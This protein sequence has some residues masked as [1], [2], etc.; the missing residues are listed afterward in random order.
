MISTVLV[1]I[2]VIASRDTQIFYAFY[3]IIADSWRLPSVDPRLLPPKEFLFSFALDPRIFS[4]KSRTMDSPPW[5]RQ[6]TSLP[7]LLDTVL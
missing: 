7:R 5:E 6:A 1:E 3:C 4:K 2:E